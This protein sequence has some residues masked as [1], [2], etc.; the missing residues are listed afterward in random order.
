MKAMTREC[1]VR[2]VQVQCILVC[3]GGNGGVSVQQW[4]AVE[5][6]GKQWQQLTA[7]VVRPIGEACL[8]AWWRKLVSWH[9]MN[10]KCQC[11]SE[12]V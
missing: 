3:N 2:R 5:C 7:H 9:A 4:H 10:E 6:P 1:D 11:N 8:L 12:Q